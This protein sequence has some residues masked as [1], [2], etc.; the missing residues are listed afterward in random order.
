MTGLEAKVTKAQLASS[1]KQD[2]HFKRVIA[3]H[4]SSCRTMLIA[5]ATTCHLLSIDH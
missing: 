2:S 3:K 5:F 4:L 1:G